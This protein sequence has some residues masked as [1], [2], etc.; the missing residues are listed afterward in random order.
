MPVGELGDAYHMQPLYTSAGGYVFGRNAAGDYDPTDLGVGNPASIEAAKKIS[1]L[2]SAGAKVLS[3]S[4]SGDNYIS[5]FAAGKSPFLLSGPWA[6]ADIEKA[7]LKYEI[8]PVP[9]FAGAGPAKPFA[10]VQAFFV[11]S[12]GKNKAFAQ[13]FVTGTM[14]TPEAMQ[15]MFDLAKLPPALTA[16][17]ESVGATDPQLKAYLDAA[18]A[19]EPMP[20]IPQ[21]QAVFGPLGKAYAAI[22]GGADPAQTM[23]ATGQTITEEI[24]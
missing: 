20:A 12:K 19:G 7:G 13:E 5:L 24:G 2:G 15:T 18:N 4:I 22:V 14:N 9:G 21:M 17:Q 11:A 8:Q 1:A 23:T 10:G 3:P 16:L 6:R